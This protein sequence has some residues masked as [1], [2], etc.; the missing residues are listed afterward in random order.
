MRQLVIEY[1]LEGRARGYAFTSSTKGFNDD[2]LKAVWRSAMPRGQGW[3]AE[4]YRGA[5][6]LKSFA[7]A[8]GRLALSAVTVTD[9]R[10][11]TGRGGIRRA[12]IA[13]MPPGEYAQHLSALLRQYPPSIQAELSRKSGL[14]ERPRIPRAKSDGQIVL[15][16]PYRHAAE[17]RLIEALLVKAALD[18]YHGGWLAGRF[19]S[20][21]TLALD[22]REE[23]AL[24][25]L[26]EERAS[27][28]KEV[29]AIRIA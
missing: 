2:T 29:K 14:F 18:E 25:V 1:V 5:R 17:W 22:Y 19:V 12:E 13:I 28:L 11:E 26:P 8:D 3:G 20:F 23:S 16:Y 15:S 6:A 21:T 10:D 4:V 9:Q 7:L 27:Q 24:V